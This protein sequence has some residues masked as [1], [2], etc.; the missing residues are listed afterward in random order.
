MH[1]LLPIQGVISSYVVENK[2]EISGFFSYYH[3]RSSILQNQKHDKLFS[4]Y[5]FYNVVTN[6]ILLDDLISDALLYAYNEGCDVFNCLT[7]MENSSF[8][9]LLKF[10]EGNG[11]LHYYI[12]NWTTP[13]LNPNEVG[14]VLL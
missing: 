12:Y 14:I 11:N 1:W 8:L 7:V 13:I 6:N 5:S 3:L 2:G 4:A 9:E 10:G